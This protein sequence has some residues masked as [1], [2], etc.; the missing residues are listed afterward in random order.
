M[1]QPKWRLRHR[2][3]I[4]T[5]TAARPRRTSAHHPK[6]SAAGLFRNRLETGS[7][8]LRP[9]LLEPPAEPLSRGGPAIVV[10]HRPGARRCAI[11]AEQPGSGSMAGGGEEIPAFW[12][13]SLD[14]SVQ[15]LPW[16]SIGGPCV[17]FFV[18]HAAP[19][20]GSVAPVCQPGLVLVPAPC[21]IHEKAHDRPH[22]VAPS[23]KP[24]GKRGVGRRISGTLA[25]TST[26]TDE[27]TQR[28][29]IE[30]ATG[31][32]GS[33]RGG[34]ASPCEALQPAEPLGVRLI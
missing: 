1:R 9:L 2:Y 22:R 6:R 32:Q 14:H 24:A 12:T 19:F 11:G 31:I 4:A 5:H 8:L 17:G 18:L 15:R 21:P 13:L 10:Q 3:G 34:P 27:R 20:D 29:L 16:L 26:T 7:Y 25:C 28:V 23:G 33:C 30:L